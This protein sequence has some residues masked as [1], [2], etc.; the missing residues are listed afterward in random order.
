MNGCD[1]AEPRSPVRAPADSPMSRRTE[2]VGNLI[3][4]T[5][6]QLLLTKM[7]DPRVDPAKTSITRV[8]IPEDLLTARV[9]VSVIGTE[10][11][12][13]NTLRALSGASGHLQELMM[14]QIKLRCTPILEFVLDENF[15]K[16]LRTLAL[17]RQ[18]MVE[19][20][21]EEEAGQTQDAPGPETEPRDEQ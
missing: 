5:V 1:P 11:Q 2:R 13:R 17:I 3:R 8:E 15:K 12:Q 4:N 10:A 14:R 7:S 20:E 16:T 21:D 6:G 19:I 18:A 9:Y